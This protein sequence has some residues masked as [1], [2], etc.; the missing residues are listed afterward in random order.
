MTIIVETPD[1]N[2]YAY[3]GNWYPGDNPRRVTLDGEFVLV[4]ITDALDEA[5]SAGMASWPWRHALKKSPHQF[6][7]LVA[8]GLDE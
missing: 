3:V 2:D 8:L 4:D 6:P 1:D 5:Y 7:A